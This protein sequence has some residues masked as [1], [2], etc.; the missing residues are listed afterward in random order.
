[1]APY[2]PRLLHLAPGRR[3]G[4]SRDTMK[5]RPEID[6]GAGRRDIH[7]LCATQPLS[8][9][10][11]GKSRVGGTVLPGGWQGGR[12]ALVLEGEAGEMR[13]GKWVLRVA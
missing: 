1:M 11:R 13:C 10:L 3:V 6:R 12:G 5:D 8:R 4:L 7:R 9:R 2:A